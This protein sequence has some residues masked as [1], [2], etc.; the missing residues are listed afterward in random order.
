MKQ[1]IKEV[2]KQCQKKHLRVKR[3]KHRFWRMDVH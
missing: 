3:S 2:Y 1:I